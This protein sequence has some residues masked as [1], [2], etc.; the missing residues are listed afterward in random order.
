MSRWIGSLAICLFFTILG[1]GGTETAPNPHDMTRIA[2]VL[3]GP[4]PTATQWELVM[5][6][7]VH[8]D[9]D[10]HVNLLMG[11]VYQALQTCPEIKTAAQL[12][13]HFE[14]GTLAKSFPHAD[15]EPSKCI[16]EA[17][18]NASLTIKTKETAQITLGIRRMDATVNP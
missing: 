12:E 6:L 10:E 15:D 8:M 16:A 9:N 13:L 18:S 17:M 4:K 14:G 7:P 2:V 5:Q 1:C 3:N 11:S